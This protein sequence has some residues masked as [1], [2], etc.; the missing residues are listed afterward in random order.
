MKGAITE[1][2]Q[3][4]LALICDIKKAL[5][6]RVLILLPLLITSCFQDK[7]SEKMG[8]TSP[9]NAPSS[10]SIVSPASEWGSDSTPTV[11]VEGVQSGNTVTLFFDSTCSDEA[12][13]VVASGN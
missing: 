7:A 13:S 2:T 12:G 6:L 10:L 11:R 1:S 8:L 3:N 5:V 9:P 4:L